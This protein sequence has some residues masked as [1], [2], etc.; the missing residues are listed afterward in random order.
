MAV[1][2][3]AASGGGSAAASGGRSLGLGFPS[4]R[5]SPWV[6]WMLEAMGLALVLVE[7]VHFKDKNDYWRERGRG[8]TTVIARHSLLPNPE[9]LATALAG[10]FS[11]AAG[12]LVFKFATCHVF[13]LFF[14]FVQ[15]FN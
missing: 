13:F 8:I 2:S 14:S 9:H 12:Q 10:S 4:A 6:M 11:P 15:A 1:G 5:S 3:L 7:L